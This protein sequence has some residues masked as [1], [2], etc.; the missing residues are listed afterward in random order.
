MFGK[1]DNELAVGVVIQEG[2]EGI[3][4]DG[5]LDVPVQFFDDALAG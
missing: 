5:A 3:D 1:K 4:V 2:G